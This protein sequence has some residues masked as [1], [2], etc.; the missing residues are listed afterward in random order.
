MNWENWYFQLL[1]NGIKHHE[2]LLGYI[3]GRYINKMTLYMSYSVLI[4]MKNEA[5]PIGC[6]IPISQ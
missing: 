5:R 2:M 1:V 3:D 6:P 4:S